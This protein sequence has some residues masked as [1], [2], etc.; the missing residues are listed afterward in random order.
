ARLVGGSP[1]LEIRYLV[2]GR[3]RRL[4]A[5][6]ES[7]NMTGSVKDRMAA[8]ILRRAQERGMLKPGDTIVECSSGNTGIAFAALGAALGHPVRIWMPDWMSAERTALIRSFGAEVVPVSR[9]QG[10]FLAGVRLAAEYAAEHDDAFEP[11]QFD[12]PHHPEAHELT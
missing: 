3:P 5:K 7:M 8:H 6:Y 2:D 10:G 11:R 12:N 9:E 4:Y 1:L